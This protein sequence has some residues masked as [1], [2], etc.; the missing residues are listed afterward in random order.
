MSDYWKKTGEMF[1]KLIDKPKMHE[2]YL[3]KPPPKYI[4]QIVINTMKKTGFPKT[5]SV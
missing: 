2:K 5:S 3:K 4:Y 1:E